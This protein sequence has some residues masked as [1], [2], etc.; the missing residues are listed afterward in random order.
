MRFSGKVSAE[1]SRLD[2]QQSLSDI[3]L[4]WPV[5]ALRLSP[6]AQ[7]ELLSFSCREKFSLLRKVKL[8]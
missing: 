7:M 8:G 6:V 3:L 4:Y 5:L 1:I 2:S